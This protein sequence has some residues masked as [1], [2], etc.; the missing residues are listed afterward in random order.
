MF[1]CKLVLSYLSKWFYFKIVAIVTDGGTNM[2]AAVRLFEANSI[3]SIYCAAHLLNLCVRDVLDNNARLV[4][5][6]SKCRSIVGSF[7]HSEPLNK[8]LI[9]KQ[10]YYT[11]RYSQKDFRFCKLSQDVSTRW[12]ST[13]LMIES[14]LRNQEPL[15]D[16]FHDRDYKQAKLSEQEFSILDQVHSILKPFKELTDLISGSKYVTATAIFPAIY[17][18]FHTILPNIRSDGG[19]GEIKKKLLASLQERFDFVLGRNPSELFLGIFFLIYF[20]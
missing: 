20:L 16:I 2:L 17:S 12:N 3:M 15:L 9:E 18:L 11:E 8:K 14:I 13:Y 7:K 4:E 6:I 5:S 19:S 10:K 1:V